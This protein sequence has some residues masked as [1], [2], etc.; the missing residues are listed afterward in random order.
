MPDVKIN[1]FAIPVRDVAAAA[2]FYEAVFQQALIPMEGPDGEMRAFTADGTP[3]GALVGHGTPGGRGV[4][5]YFDAQGDLDAM[6]ERTS[7]A[8]GTIVLP[9][10]SI[11]EDGHFARIADADGNTIGLHMP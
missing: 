2:R 1:W 9:R 3:V 5:L 6:L 7:A 11:G 8:G 4:D 10:T